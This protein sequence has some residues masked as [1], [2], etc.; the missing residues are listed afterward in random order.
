MT[1]HEISTMYV[2]V[3]IRSASAMSTLNNTCFPRQ[4]RK[5]YLYMYVVVF[6]RSVSAMST[7]NMFSWTNKKNIYAGF[8]LRVL[9]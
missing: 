9:K 4:I 7:N 3:F 6:I 2:V 1:T 8:S 5:K